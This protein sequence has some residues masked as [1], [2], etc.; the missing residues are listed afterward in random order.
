VS[1]TPILDCEQPL[2]IVK[3]HWVTALL[4]GFALGGVLIALDRSRGSPDP[5]IP[6]QGFPLCFAA[7]Y[8][9]VLAHELG[10][11]IAG[12]TVRFELRALMVGAFF[13]RKE[14]NGWRFR[15]VPRY[16][17]AG[18][19]TM[20][21]PHSADDLWN[22]HIRFILGGPAGSLLLLI[23]TLLLPR[24]LATGILFWVNLLVSISA[25]VPY[26][27][28]GQPS[29]A[30][31]IL[32]LAQKGAVGERL[33]TIL[34]LLTLDAQGKQPREWPSDSVEKL[35]VPTKDQSWVPT[36]LSLLLSDAADK[37]DA[38]RTAEILERALATSKMWPDLRRGFRAA[39]SGYHGFH[40]SDVS[41]AEE[42]LKH[43][44]SV[45]G[46]TALKDWDCQ[47]L[48]AVSFAKGD[49]FQSAELLTRYV[50][51]LDRQPVSGRIAAERERTMVLLNVLTDRATRT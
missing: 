25:I 3:I 46:G 32:R 6:P 27:L 20:A 5:L 14:A 39:A 13:L 29:D 35:A 30:K 42:W 24:G 34:Y 49:Y 8:I 22:R 43:A 38:N 31:I 47:A 12:A 26:T 50:A 48:A 4:V 28:A 51:L 18:G 40:R 23:I 33:A 17:L 10:H 21:I 37:E 9:A 2:P 16:L 19:F 1:R 15:F 41:R 44:R 11:A 7:F 36:A 45:K